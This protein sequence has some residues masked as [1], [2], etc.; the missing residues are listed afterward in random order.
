MRERRLTIRASLQEMMDNAVA[1]V[2]ALHGAIA[3]NEL[4]P[5][6]D[7][8]VE[9]HTCGAATDHR[10]RR[11]RV[12]MEAMKDYPRLAEMGVLHPSQIVHFSVNSIDQI[13]VLRIV[14]KRPKGSILPMART[15]RF[16]RVQT[17]GTS[18][19]AAGGS[20]PVMGS[21]PVLREAVAELEKLMEARTTAEDVVGTIKD[22]L[23][24]LEEDVSLRVALIKERL[25]KIPPL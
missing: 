10:I 5:R 18:S 23:V 16:P 14:Y 2:A 1:A 15:Y 24:L 11:E 3:A 8:A 20:T 6:L 13:D 4:R 17:S 9:A 21:D 25:A 22:E 19:G 7:G 12:F